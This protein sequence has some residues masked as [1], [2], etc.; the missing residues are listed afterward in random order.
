MKRFKNILV[1]AQNITGKNSSLKIAASLAALNKARITVVD[2]VKDLSAYMNILPAASHSSDLEDQIIQ[3]HI[4]RLDHMIAPFADKG[5][6]I[7][8]K[9]LRG[10]PFLEIIREVLKK[11]HDL[12]VITPEVQSGFSEI[13]FGSTTMHLMRK[14]PCP[15]LAI[16]PGQAE[17]F[18]RILA[19][20]DFEPADNENTELNAKIMEMSLS[21]AQMHGGEIHAV[22]SC[23]FDLKGMRMPGYAVLGITE[24][25]QKIHFKWFNKLVKKHVPEAADDQI[26]CL[27]GE[28]ASVIP[29]LIKKMQ[30]DIIVMSTIGKT[31]V[32]GFFIGNTAE[33]LLHRV[34]C[35]VLAVKPE[36]YISP[37][38][39]D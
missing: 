25:M 14:C 9:V 34:G 18:S 5:I 32:P 19:A 15:V 36:G 27:E 12:V 2:V 7:S 31:D 22:H 13:L 29:K 21:L 30:I 28:A 16:K 11:Q 8:R 33:K 1:A 3:D 24:E 17:K 20:I 38:R 35:S 26:H 10:T 6:D 23:H 39:A 37:V 4:E